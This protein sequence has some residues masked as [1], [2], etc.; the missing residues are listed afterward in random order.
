MVPMGWD[1]QVEAAS[2]P[3][4]LRFRVDGGLAADRRSAVRVPIAA[5]AVVRA[6]GA[7]NDCRVIDISA[8]GMRLRTP[9]RRFAP[10]TTVHVR[11]QLPAGGPMLDCNAVVRQAEPGI[12]AVEFADLPAERAAEIGLWAVERLRSSLAAG[13]G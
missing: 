3:G 12:A 8:G 5:E 7:D 1:G 6:L 11:S 13:Q 10:G 4:E 9:G 2:A